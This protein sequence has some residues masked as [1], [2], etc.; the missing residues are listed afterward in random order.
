MSIVPFV[1][2]T[3]ATAYGPV[4]SMKWSSCW[5]CDGICGDKQAS[6]TWLT[7]AVPGWVKPGARVEIRESGRRRFLGRLNEPE[8]TDGGFVCSAYGLAAMGSDREALDASDKP[9]WDPN[10]AID[11]AIARGLPWSRWADFGTSGAGDA[12]TENAPSVDVRTLL[13]RVAQAAGKRAVVDQWGRLL[14]GTDPT[15]PT[16]LVDGMSNYISAAD[17]TFIARMVGLYSSL[18]THAVESVAVADPWAASH[19]DVATEATV[20]LTALG[21]ISASA[22]LANITAR[23]SLVGARMAPTAGFTVPRLRLQAMNGAPGSPSAI[24]A[25]EMLRLRGVRDFQTT[26]RNWAAMD[27]IAGE[28]EYDAET[29]SAAVTPLGYVPRD[30]TTALA[31]AQA[32]ETTDATEAA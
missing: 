16:W 17:D 9:T 10:V 6:W 4:T 7:D 23:M 1:A 31:A 8:R 27:L 19:F 15:A 30:M 20:D 13:L 25:G 21:E 28:V 5:V 22:A 18:L 24:R 14:L 2:G 11:Q 32:P 26:T 12:S 3:P 29:D